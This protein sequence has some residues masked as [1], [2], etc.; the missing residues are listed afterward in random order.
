[1][2]LEA[3]Q[4][5]QAFEE[6]IFRF[7]LRLGGIDF[8]QGRIQAPLGPFGPLEAAGL[9]DAFLKH[10]AKLVGGDHAGQPRDQFPFGADDK[11]A[12]EVFGIIDLNVVNFLEELDFFAPWWYFRKHKLCCYEECS[13]AV[14]FEL[15][16]H[17]GARTSARARRDH[18]KQRQAAALAFL[19]LV[20]EI[21][22][23]GQRRRKR[24]R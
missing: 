13:F 8:L 22:G 9:F 24:H 23:V 16:P 1:M 12:G 19:G 6:R 18:H 3:Y 4:R 5:Q 14:F 15:L 2:T 20:H 17:G 10:L 21:G 11:A 7:E